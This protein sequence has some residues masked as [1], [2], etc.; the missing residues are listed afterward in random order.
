[1]A[2]SADPALAPEVAPLV[3]PALLAP[4]EQALSASAVPRPTA[5]TFEV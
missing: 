5:A 4:V 1:M 3:D 2:A